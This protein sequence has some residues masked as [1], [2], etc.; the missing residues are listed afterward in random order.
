[1]RH[2]LVALLH[3]RAGPPAATAASCGSGV[4]RAHAVPLGRAQQLDSLA[5]RGRGAVDVVSASAAATPAAAIARDAVVDLVAAAAAVALAV[6]S[7]LWPRGGAPAPVHPPRADGP[8]RSGQ[9]LSYCCIINKSRT[10]TKVFR[11]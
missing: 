4:G 9:V 6:G 3:H 11:V 10:R 2:K 1:M 5:G 7:S 8:E